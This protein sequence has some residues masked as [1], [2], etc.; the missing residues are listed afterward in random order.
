MA[1]GNIKRYEMLVNEYD[2]AD[3]LD[4]IE[5][6]NADECWIWNGTKVAE[7]YGVIQRRKSGK[8]VTIFTHRL[9]YFIHKGEIPQD[10]VIDHYCH[11]LALD[12]CLIKTECKHRAC[13]NPDHLR[14]ITA[15]ENSR[16]KRAN[17]NAV[18]PL[19][20][21]QFRREKRGTCRKGHAW[22]EE[23][24]ITRKSGRVDCLTCRKNHN[25]KSNAKVGA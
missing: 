8:T 7:G 6:G 11:T 16:I 4:R 3:F 23:N 19:S 25:A 20:T 1:A 14:A 22:I 5:K 2:V 10:L 15:Q 13:V 18:P 9:S 21:Y 12:T 17:R 24:M